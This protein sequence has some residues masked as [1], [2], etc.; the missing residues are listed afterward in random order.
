MSNNV[1]ERVVDMQFNNKQFESNVQTSIKSLDALKSGLN[2]DASAKSLANLDKAGKSFSLAG[3]ASGVDAISSKFSALGIIGITALQNITNSAI[4]AGKKL[5]SALTVDPIKTG[6]T[7]YETKMGAI[8]TILT[9][10]ASKGTTLEDVNKV[11]GELNEYSDKTIYNFAEMA[12]NIGT[13]TAAGVDLNV[14]ATAIKGIAN[15][16]AGSGSN[17]QQ[18]STAMYQLSQALAAGSVKLMDWNSVVNAGMGGELFQNALKA[19]AKEM[20]V[21]VDASKPFRETLQDG[22]ITS[23][24]LTKTLAKFA[25]DESLVKAATQVKTFTQLFDTMKE[26]V[27]SGWAVSWENIIGDKDQAAKTLTAINDAFGALIGPSTDAR[28]EMLKFWNV[29]GGR[30][31]L[32]EGV[33]SALQG[34]SSIIKPI[35]EALTEIFPAMTGEKLVEITKHIRDLTANFKIGDETAN[36]IKRTFKGLFALLDI[37]KQAILA[38]TGGLGKLLKSLLPAGDGLLSF[39]GSIGDWLVALDE[40][41]KT[42]GIFNVAIEKIGNF[43]KKVS[44]G[45]KIAVQTIADTIKSFANIDTSGIEAFSDKMKARFE[46]FSKIVEIAQGAFAKMGEVLKKFA[47]VFYKLSEIIGAAFG[48]MQDRILNALDTANFDSI[49]DIINGGLFAAILLG[50]RKF[51]SS[52]TSITD[53]AGGFFDGIIGILDGVKGSLE[54]YQNSLKAGTL[55]KIA[56]AIGILAAA[57]VVLSTIDSKKLTSSLAAMSVMFVQL[58]GSMGVFSKIMG[59]KGFKGLPKVTFAMISLS[60]AILILSVAMTKLASLDWNGLAKGL[61]GVA[62]LMTMMVGAAKILSANGKAMIRGSLGFVIFAAAINVLVS[63]VKS[64]SELSWEQLTKGLV[65]VGVLMTE[66]AIFMKVTDLSGM[67]PLKGAGILLL[68][69]AINVLADAV[70]KFAIMDPGTLLK[71]LAAVAIVLTELAFFVNLTGSAKNVIVTAIGLTILGAAMLIFAQAIGTMGDLSWEQIAKGLTAMAGSLALITIAVNLMPKTMILSAL[72]LVVI[73]SALVILAQ[74]LQTM[75]GMSWEQMAIGLITLAGSLTIIALAMTFMT[76]ALPGA[77]AL[78]IVAAALAILAPVLKT[79]GSMSLKEIGLGLLALVGVFAV[80]GVAGLVLAPLTPVL[81]GLGVAMAL[82]GVGMMAVGVGILAFSAGLAALAVSGTA[83]AA[84]LVLIVTSLIGLVPVFLKKV[85]EG[86]I[87]FAK[88]IADGGPAMFEALTVVLTSLIDAIIVI[89]P[90]AIE[91]LMLLITGLL[92]SLAEAVPQMIDSGMKLILGILR[93]IADN[94]ADVVA[95]GIDVILGFIEGVVSK[96]PAIIDAA[97]KVIIGF[98]NGLAEAIRNNSDAIYDATG[99]LI[100]AIVDSLLSFGKKI[101]DAGKNIVDGIIEGIKSMATAA[102]NAAKDLGQNILDSVLSFFGIKS[103]SRLMRD[104]VG[105]YIVQGIAEGI[106]KDMSAEE[107]ATKKAENIVSAF[108]TELDRISSEANTAGLEYDLWSIVNGDAS[109]SGKS[110]KEIEMLSKKILLQQEKVNLAASEYQTTLKTLG[111]NAPQT[112]DA[113][114]KYLEEQITLATLADQIKT[115]TQ[116]NAQANSASMDEYY[117]IL[118][119]TEL[120]K[121]LQNSGF[122][123]AEIEAYARDKSG[124]DPTGSLETSMATDVKSAVTGAMKTVTAVYEKTADATFGGLL[125]SIG[126]WGGSYATALGEGF[127][128]AFDVI[129]E[130]IKVSLDSVENV[131]V[132][133]LTE[134]SNNILNAISGMADLVPTITPVLDL[135]NVTSG[136][137]SLNSMMGQNGTISVAGIGDK[138]SAIVSGMQISWAKDIATTEQTNPAQPISFVQYNYSPT[139]LSRIDIYR[140][141]KN[142]ISTVK[143]LV[144]G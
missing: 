12:R 75:G 4:N 24:V 116:A 55:L 38:I 123:Q 13:F 14:S 23:E 118:S 136:V 40:A 17:A 109:E 93:G 70:G 140:Q 130:K 82:L 60:I 54:A 134:I 66:L 29:N 65:G 112:R 36:N 102:W 77:A 83:G 142:Q 33:T 124:F 113:Y 94:I 120:I 98:I 1:D 61:V 89:I 64:L 42:S 21:V 137:N 119:N 18:A 108:K 19:T 25:E 86:I 47:P 100:T 91:A 11:L 141:T 51:I 71:G 127:L 7:E 85:G 27:Q 126:E 41:I 30:D 132:I 74:A 92:K 96:L 144:G 5:V 3:I 26:S 103:P 53:G 90:K 139:A 121:A 10:T 67:G 87:A 76:G 110:A 114:N 115:A 15:L 59:S 117:K 97:F 72:S 57:L 73:A 39:T 105:V 45:I 16:A 122:T 84:A 101:L 62:A 20:G 104:K 58:F 106:T 125:E 79:L 48:H 69:A 111:A 95:A 135:T 143:G 88:V 107:A 78:L 49:F 99:N 131:L 35:K 128:K 28:N 44:D 56:I 63:A 43:I 68:A 50:I 37:G 81:I 9:N 2:L 138:I 129:M 133:R 80:L 22:W 34:L 52:L 32:I 31:A 8:Q 46:P 6:L